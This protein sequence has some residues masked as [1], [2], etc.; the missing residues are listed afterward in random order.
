MK[1]AKKILVVSIAILAVAVI[2]ITAFAAS[3]YETPAEAVAGLTGRTTQSVIDERKES[4]K[5]YGAIAAEA[6]Q[7]DNFKAEML[8]IQKD[9]LNAQV[10]AVKITQEEADD[11]LAKIEENQAECD[12]SESAHKGS[13]YG[14]GKGS[15]NKGRKMQGAGKGDGAG[16]GQGQRMRR[17]KNQ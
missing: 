10:K 9:R 3:A 4:N 12:G 1:H 13:G 15:G 16:L 8:E 11:I 5:P 6:G 2:S 17:G 7:L 14:F